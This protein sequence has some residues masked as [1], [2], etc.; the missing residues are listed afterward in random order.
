MI[1]DTRGVSEVLGYILI[2]SLVLASITIVSTVGLGQIQEVRDVEQMNNAEA[3]FDLLATNF[4][5]LTRRGAPSRSTEMQLATGQLEITDSIDV[6]FEG[7]TESGTTAFNESYD[8]RPLLYRGT[9]NDRAVVYSSGAIF[10]TYA[11]SGT[12]VRSPAIVASDDRV[13]IS[14]V[15]TRA[16]SRESRG[17]GTARLRATHAQTVMLALDTEGTY[18]RVHMNVTSPR[19]HLWADTL[20][21]YEEFTCSLDE[22]GTVDRAACHVDDPERLQIALVQIDIAI[23]A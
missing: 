15:H 5:D 4:E 12:T 19:A 9:A 6:R 7:I 17:G 16:A 11:G 13:S 1:S 23:N 14:L 22:S 20:S 21:E 2:F 18:D 3:A 8:V 10:R